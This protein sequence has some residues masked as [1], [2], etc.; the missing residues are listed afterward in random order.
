MNITKIINNQAKGIIDPENII[1]LVSTHYLEEPP[2]GDH[3]KYH[4]G[5]IDYLTSLNTLIPLSIET[6]NS[7]EILTCHD[8]FDEGFFDLIPEAI[9]TLIQFAWVYKCLGNEE[10]SKKLVDIIE[11]RLPRLIEYELESF[12]AETPYYSKLNLAEL[13]LEYH[14][15]IRETYKILR[16]HKH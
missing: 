7:E 12:S 10:E 4:S 2:Q 1:I 6:V 16:P 5:T 14:K 11:N 3:P 13:P 8:I 15:V 9:E